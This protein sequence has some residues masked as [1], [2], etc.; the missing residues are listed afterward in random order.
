MKASNCT[1]GSARPVLMYVLLS[2]VPAI[3]SALV[4]M[5][6]LKEFKAVPNY[7]GLVI[8]LNISQHHVIQL[9]AAA[10][11]SVQ[12]GTLKS[13]GSFGGRRSGCRVLS[14]V[15]SAVSLL[16][17]LCASLGIEMC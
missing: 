16:L 17:W 5:S 12:V 6:R 7:S 4:A 13:S 11:S 10:W 1:F 2:S 14:P 3:D 9:L 8:I 15:V